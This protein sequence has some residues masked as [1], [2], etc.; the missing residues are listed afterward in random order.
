MPHSQSCATRRPDVVVTSLSPTTTSLTASTEDDASRLAT[1]EVTIEAL[2]GALVEA[3]DQLLAVYDLAGIHAQSLDEDQAVQHVLGEACRLLSCDRAVLVGGDGSAPRGFS[4]DDLPLDR[5]AEQGR[6]FLAGE[7]AGLVDESGLAAVIVK[8]ESPDAPLALVLGRDGDSFL[9]GERRLAEAIADSLNGV[10]TT[11]AL[12]R[13]ALLASE[14]Q[15]AATLAQM[16]LPK[17]LPDLAGVDMAAVSHPARAA[18]GDFFAHTVLDGI[19]HFVVGDVSGKGLPAAIM[20]ATL[21]SASNAAIRRYGSE[22][23]AAVLAGIDEDAHEYLSDAGLFATVMVGCFDPQDG[24]ARFANAGHGPLLVVSDSSVASVPASV[25][26]IGVVPL[27]GIETTLCV[28]AP[29]A[30]IV[31]GSDGLTE[32]ENRSGEM[33]GDDG[34]VSIVRHGLGRSS[35]QIVE[36]TFAEVERFADGA[37]QS[38]DRTMLV[39]QRCDVRG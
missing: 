6:S 25:P 39:V 2:T 1:A 8:V 15:T 35:A 12:H 26:P 17:R 19:L 16:A 5:L 32:Q 11:S 28:L 24:T 14:H 27:T 18:G 7:H 29:G 37:E 38:D 36:Y 23:P 9:T 22:G 4:T 20:M 21:V 10:L 30:A 33:V 13:Q 34:L 31:V 3:N